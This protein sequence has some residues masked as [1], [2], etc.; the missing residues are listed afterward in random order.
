M[1]VRKSPSRRWIRFSLRSLA[2]VVMLASFGCAHL[3]YKFDRAQRRGIAVKRLSE[4]PGIVNYVVDGERINARKVSDLESEHSSRLHNWMTKQLGFDYFND[5]GHVCLAGRNRFTDADFAMT[6]RLNELK[7]LRLG[8]TLVTD[9]GFEPI[10]ELTE[11]ELLAISSPH[12][13]DRALDHLS[14]LPKLECLYLSD[15]AVTDQGVAKLASLGK[16]K[17]V[18]LRKTHVTAAG[19][20]SLQTALPDCE[21]TLSP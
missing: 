17:S 3:F 7:S 16:L 21:I 4:F 8:Q 14:K 20:K 13:T 5:V 12:L 19:V 11:L 9:E 2:V 18:A 10:C 1:C 15:V 6:C